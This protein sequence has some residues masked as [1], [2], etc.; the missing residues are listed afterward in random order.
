MAKPVK[1]G[2][3][4]AWVPAMG[5]GARGSMIPGIGAAAAWEGT[6]C[7]VKN[8]WIAGVG[9]GG[10]AGGG[11]NPV[12]WGAAWGAVGCGLGMGGGG[13]AITGGG[14]T[15]CG[16]GGGGGGG[17]M[18]AGAAGTGRGAGA[19]GGGGANCCCAGA[20]GRPAVE[21]APAEDVW[22]RVDW[23]S[24]IDEGRRLPWRAVYFALKVSMTIFPMA[25]RVVKT[26]IP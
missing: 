3:G 26:P 14:A 8:P 18:G 21:A 25:F 23:V 19:W 17:I 22:G 11:A 20:A 7:E 9:A 15:G 6:A 4:A 24:G 10:G 13:G 16:R 2:S 5:G 1:P 12:N